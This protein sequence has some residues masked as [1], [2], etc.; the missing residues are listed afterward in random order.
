MNID[1]NSRQVGIGY[2][3]DIDR[4]RL[5][6]G[7]PITKKLLIEVI[8]TTSIG[9]KNVQDRFSI[10]ENTHVVAGG[11]SQVDSNIIIPLSCDDIKGTRV[12]RTEITIT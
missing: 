10:D 1:Q 6:E 8:P 9:I 7:N 4:T 11:V 5:L 2:V 3:P 12:L